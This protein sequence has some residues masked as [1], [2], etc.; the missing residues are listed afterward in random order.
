MITSLYL[1]LGLSYLPQLKCKHSPQDSASTFYDN[2]DI[3][4]LLRN[5]V[6]WSYTL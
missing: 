6:K 2:G 4:P 1:T 3:N 5:V